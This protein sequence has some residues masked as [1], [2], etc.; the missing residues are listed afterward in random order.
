VVAVVPFDRDAFLAAMR[1]AEALER[2]GDRAGA[3]SELQSLQHSDPARPEPAVRLGLLDA[4]DGDHAGAIAHFSTALPFEQKP[5]RVLQLRATS[6][7]ALGRIDE[8]SR[9]VDA[10]LTHDAGN[11]GT[12]LLHARVLIATARTREARAIV[13]ALLAFQEH[14]EAL[15]LSAELH[16]LDGDPRTAAA[17][18]ARA[19]DV[20]AGPKGLF[21]RLWKPRA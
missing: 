7:L 11:P 5:S 14:P 20:A 3:R 16:E 9:D 10:A 6:Y 13:D 17:E 8:A 4:R 15:E 2:E 18:R 12:R 21:N 1:R 19:A